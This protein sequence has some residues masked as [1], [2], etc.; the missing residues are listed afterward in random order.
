M[1]TWQSYTGYYV[2]VT[3]DQFAAVTGI[4]QEGLTDAIVEYTWKPAHLNP[5]FS[6][7]KGIGLSPHQ[8]SMRFKLYEDG[9]R[10]DCPH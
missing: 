9:W 3:K 10:A 1:V 5:A 7:V 4:P 6:D 2:P 8:S